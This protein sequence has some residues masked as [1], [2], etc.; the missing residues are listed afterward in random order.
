MG[1]MLVVIFIA[2]LELE[3]KSSFVDRHVLGEIVDFKAIHL[4]RSCPGPEW[5]SRYLDKG[6]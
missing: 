1:N 5:P 6:E 3:K 2:L 4:N